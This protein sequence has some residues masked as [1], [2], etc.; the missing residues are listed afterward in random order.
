MLYIVI[1]VI[2]IL[3]ASAAWAGFKAAP[4]V[5]TWAKDY[6]R[7]LSL[8]HV[9]NGEQVLELGAGEGRLVLQFAKTPAAQVIGYELSLLPFA[10]AWLRTRKFRPRVQMRMADFFRAD[11]NRADVIF[12]F[13]TPPAM[14]KLKVKFEQECRPGTRIISYTFSIPGWTPDVMDKNT[15]T[16][17]PIYRYIIGR[18]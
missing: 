5:P 6:S 16:A 18:T 4:W 17:V 1:G 11:Y 10:I 15:P 13:L 2:F 12:C 14:R 9:Q 3:M 7:I 8:A